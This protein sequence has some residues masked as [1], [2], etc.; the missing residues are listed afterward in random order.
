M[1]PTGCIDKDDLAVSHIQLLKQI[2]GQI[3]AKTN[4]KFGQL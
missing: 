4:T 2:N 3:G 1:M